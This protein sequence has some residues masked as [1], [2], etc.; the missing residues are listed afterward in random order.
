MI[1]SDVAL[2]AVGDE[3]AG[4]LAEQ[5]PAAIDAAASRL[6]STLEV[7]PE[8]RLAR[9]ETLNK[10][11]RDRV[12][13]LRAQLKAAGKP[14]R[15]HNR[16][17]LDRLVLQATFRAASP[18]AAI[19]S[20]QR[21]DNTNSAVAQA[22]V[23]TTAE[24]STQTVASSMPLIRSHR[25]LDPSSMSYPPFT[26]GQL[27]DQATAGLPAFSVSLDG[28][29][30]TRIAITRRSVFIGGRLTIPFDVLQEVQLGQS[31]QACAAI[32]AKVR[33]TT[34]PIFQVP[35][36]GSGDPLQ[37]DCSTPEKFAS[38]FYQTICLVL[39]NVEAPA[40]G[41]EKSTQRNNDGAVPS[42][43]GRVAHVFIMATPAAF[44]AMVASLDGVDPRFEVG[45]PSRVVLRHLAAQSEVLQQLD[46]EE[47]AV[48]E[49]F[50][51]FPSRFLAAKLRL[52]AKDG[53]KLLSP[54]DVLA[55]VDMPL[56]Q[57]RRVLLH[58]EAKGMLTLHT[59]YK[60]M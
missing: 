60:V 4:R 32:A 22:S 27:R 11:L 21:D 39:P 38:L 30:S 24:H 36:E 40:K 37:L 6:V 52:F 1:S 23:V 49:Q 44:N 51:I 46:P 3:A 16:D 10:L 13:D 14:P 9:A 15:V 55:V 50:H 58:F 35:G 17:K 42:G 48:C 45:F 25:L 19:I 8:E 31:G 12:T 34:Q 2:E 18:A 41:R 5:L 56:F 26:A 28:A 20:S 7:S 59:L 43:A 53:P 33:C 54:I 29:V 47:V 57:L